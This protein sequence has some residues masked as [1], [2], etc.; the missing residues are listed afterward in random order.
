[1]APSFH[2][3]KILGIRDLT[4]D[5]KEFLLENPGGDFRAGQF[6]TIKITDGQNPQCMRSYSVLRNEGEGLQLIVKRVEGGR[7]TS[8]LFSKNVGDEIEI[9]FPLGH[10]GLPAVLARKVVFIGTGTGLAPLLCMLES[11]PAGYDGE[12]ELLFG[13]RFSVD[14]FYLERIEALK[15][16][17]KNFKFTATVSRPQDGWEGAKGRVTEYLKEVDPS[18]QYFMCGTHD[19]IMDV[20]KLLEE[21]GV[22]KENVY[23]ENFG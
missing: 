2:T 4:E 20:K 18:A 5:V 3:V 16:K 22:A 11:L 19:M 21:K 23:F 9:L 15:E 7:G 10:F 12:V 6:A 8:F 17:L 1:M 14:L 13:V